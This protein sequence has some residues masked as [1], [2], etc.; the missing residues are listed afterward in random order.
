MQLYYVVVVIILI[1]CDAVLVNWSGAVRCLDKHFTDCEL[2]DLIVTV[3]LFIT[4]VIIIHHN[5]YYHY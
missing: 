1:L 3:P 4:I 5:L 2:C